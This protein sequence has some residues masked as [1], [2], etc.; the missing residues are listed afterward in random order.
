MVWT[1]VLG[2]IRNHSV[3]HKDVVLL[4]KQARGMLMSVCAAM[5][6]EPD[7]IDRIVAFCQEL[8]E[9]DLHELFEDEEKFTQ[10]MRTKRN[11]FKSTMAG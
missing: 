7:D 8:I 1:G 4:R 11:E 10:K 5:E 3:R 6:I 2:L 9:E